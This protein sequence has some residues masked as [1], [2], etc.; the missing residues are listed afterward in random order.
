[1]GITVY[2]SAH[3]GLIITT[4]DIAKVNRVMARTVLYRFTYTSNWQINV[5]EKEDHKP[6]W[7]IAR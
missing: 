5:L 7:P 2:K 1:M 3:S 6:P 4:V